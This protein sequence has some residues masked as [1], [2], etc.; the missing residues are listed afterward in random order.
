MIALTEIRNVSEY[1]GME[2]SADEGAGCG[3]HMGSL[4]G[5]ELMKSLGE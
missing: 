1:E 3:R 5:A 2:P 4:G